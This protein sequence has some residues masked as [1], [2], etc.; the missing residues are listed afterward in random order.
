MLIISETFSGKGKVSFATIFL[1][2]N[3]MSIVSLT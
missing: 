1:F 2:L 3:V